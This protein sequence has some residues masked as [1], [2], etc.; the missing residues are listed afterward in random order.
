MCIFGLKKPTISAKIHRKSPKCSWEGGGA[1]L[2]QCL[3]IYHDFT[4]FLMAMCL[5]MNMAIGDEGQ[6]QLGG[7]LCKERTLTDWGLAESGEPQPGDYHYN[8]H[9]PYPYKS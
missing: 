8:F 3:K 6:G 4:P 1:S 7:V 5:M 2:G 9:Y